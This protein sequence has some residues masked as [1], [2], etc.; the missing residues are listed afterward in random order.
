MRQTIANKNKYKVFF[1]RVSTT[2]QDIQLQE[3]ADA[4]YRKNYIPSEILIMNEKGVS[5]N[6]LDINNRPQMNKLIQL[7]VSDQ[8]EI[9][10][11]FD[12]T[13]LFRD[14][15]ESNLFVSL[16]KKHNVKVFYT[17]AG[18]G[19]H[20]STNSTLLE[21]VMN[22]VSDVEGKNI[23]RRTEEA[24][25]RYPPKKFGYF[26]EN[27][28]FKKEPENK[29]LLLEFFKK[30]RQ[31]STHK[32]LEITLMEFRRKLNKDRKVLLKIAMDPFYAGYDLTTGKNKLLHVEP[33][34]TYEEFQQFRDNSTVI[35]T[36]LDIE[37]SLKNQDNYEVS[38]GVCKRS[39]KFH[40]NVPEVKAWYSCSHKHSKVLISTEDLILIVKKSLEK[41]IESL[42]TETLLKDSRHYF[43]LIR[44]NIDG[45]FKSLEAQKHNL[46]EK[47]ILEIDDI[48]KWRD[49]P[50]YIE[51]IKLEEIQ[52][53]LLSQLEIKKQLLL[54]NESLVDLLKKYLHK[55]RQSNSFFLTSM[56]IKKVFVYPNEVN[57]EVSK[58]DY[59]HDLQTQYIFNGGDFI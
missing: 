22:I 2:N 58:F 10:Y 8:I 36:Y 19:N 26:K 35:S 20:Q 33:Y 44:K 15:Y 1:R 17:S 14:F 38:C 6:K 11:A 50:G 16:C 21:G 29:D 37:E 4:I 28:K 12:R 46:M 24:R 3:S 51:L 34:L 54:E 23:A 13:R 55:C 27:K 49:N 41:T 9:I 31:I 40:L 45:E 47:T 52:K 48:S 7:I 30:I 42:N 56:L 32:D 25:K 18:N 57:I 5:A 43:Q 53:N 39:M 59:L